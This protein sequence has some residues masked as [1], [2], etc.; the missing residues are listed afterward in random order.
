MRVEKIGLSIG[1]AFAVMIAIGYASPLEDK[2][3]TSINRAKEQAVKE[4]RSMRLV[5]ETAKFEAINYRQIM[6]EENSKMQK[7]SNTHNELWMR[8]KDR[9]L[10]AEDYSKATLAQM[11]ELINI[12]DTLSKHVPQEW[13][14][15]S[16][17][18]RYRIT[19]YLSYLQL[20]YMY[21]IASESGSSESVLMEMQDAMKYRLNTSDHYL[22]LA[23]EINTQLSED[24]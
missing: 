14:G 1:I 7:I 15:S 21:A 4:T 10:T 3:Y 24:K 12:A 6:D 11:E 22:A 16:K 8:W 23:N 19:E 17:Y 2:T 20:S 13:E 18:T 9:E 5:H